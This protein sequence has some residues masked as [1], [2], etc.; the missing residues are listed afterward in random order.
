MDKYQ[1]L[2]I[3]SDLATDFEKT[4]KGFKDP[5]NRGKCPDIISRNFPVS[6]TEL[7]MAFMLQ[8]LQLN[9]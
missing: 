9:L 7:K 3:V 8:I 4:D 5:R 1:K 2:Q 6:G